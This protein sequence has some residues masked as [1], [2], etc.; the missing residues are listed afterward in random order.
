MDSDPAEH[1]DDL[2]DADLGL[3]GEEKAEKSKT[4]KDISTKGSAKSQKVKQTDFLTVG[5]LEWTTFLNDSL[6]S[7]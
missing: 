7:T 4:D 5:V 3:P 6:S 1:L 2:L